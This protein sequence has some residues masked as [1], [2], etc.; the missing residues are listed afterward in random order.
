MSD[1]QRVSGEG[2]ANA[3][4]NGPHA[5]SSSSNRQES[6][7]IYKGSRQKIAIVHDWLNGMRG[8]EIVFEAILDLFP[9]AEVYTLIYEPENLNARLREKLSKH[10]VRASWLNHLALTRKFYRQLLP[11]L[12]FAIRQFDLYPYDLVVSSSHCVAKGIRKHPESYH[13]SYVHAPMRYMWNKFEDYFGKGRSSALV[14]LAA[15]IFR[16]FLQA[17]DRSTS[18][19][20]RV[21]KILANSQFIARE[22]KQFYGR[23]AKVIY[24]FARLERFTRSRQ[25]GGHYLM[26]GAFAPYKRTDI[27]IEAFARLG[28][29]LKIVG[30]GQDEQRLMVLKQ[31]LDARNIE[32]L[33]SPSNDQIESLYSSCRAFIFPGE[34]D[35]GI[36]PLEAMASGAPVIAYRS[37]GACET[38]TDKTGIL[39]S[40]QTVDALCE[41][42]MDVESG[43]R[44]FDEA[45]CR[46]RAAFFS[47]ERFK[48]EFLSEL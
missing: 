7:L 9:G 5:L 19:A 12:P 27:A 16:P 36:T 47:Q 38:V 4:E 24:P 35:F 41:A 25:V 3:K 8:G 46:R 28:L 43:R 21:D 11:L 39:F 20:E 44:K 42:I 31:K 22:I 26:V 10:T 48:K 14:R 34:E 2:N 1:D 17:W 13:L 15:K 30:H 37:G 18:R 45:E 6:G 40:P 32:F 33:G 23:D 29:P